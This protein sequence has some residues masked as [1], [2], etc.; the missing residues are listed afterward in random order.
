MIES[1]ADAIAFLRQVASKA[2]SLRKKDP[3]EA[4]GYLEEQEVYFDDV[5]AIENQEGL[6][7]R[8]CGNII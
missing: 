4:A 2:R 7:N 8:Y 3:V 6:W 1:L 5:Y